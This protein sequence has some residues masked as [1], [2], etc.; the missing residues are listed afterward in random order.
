MGAQGARKR[1]TRYLGDATSNRHAVFTGTISSARRLSPSKPCVDS[2]SHRRDIGASDFTIS[3]T[4]SPNAKIAGDPLYGVRTHGIPFGKAPT[5]EPAVF[6]AG[7][8]CEY[9]D[10]KRSLFS[11]ASS[12]SR[13]APPKRSQMAPRTVRVPGYTGWCLAC[14]EAAVAS[15]GGRS[16]TPPG[17]S[18]RARR[19][20]HS[21]LQQAIVSLA[22]R[23]LSGRFPLHAVRRSRTARHERALLRRREQ[24][25]PRSRRRTVPREGPLEHVVRR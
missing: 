24:G 2:R 17:G 23:R 16:R 21:T 4:Q 6:P 14:P 19:T 9:F 22:S 11:S 18:R 3:R 10:H 1:R 15:T 20:A 5:S 7:S 12:V 13:H 25:E 8:L